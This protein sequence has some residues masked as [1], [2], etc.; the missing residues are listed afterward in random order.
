MHASVGWRGDTNTEDVLR[1]HDDA[2]VVDSEFQGRIQMRGTGGFVEWRFAANESE[3]RALQDSS[4][5]NVPTPR[6]GLGGCGKEFLGCDDSG[7]GVH[8]SSFDGLRVAE[9]P[10]AIRADHAS[11]REVCV[12]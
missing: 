10:H 4:T 8:V 6:S 7:F 11:Q 1:I 5:G 2:S 9:T 3:E 12:V